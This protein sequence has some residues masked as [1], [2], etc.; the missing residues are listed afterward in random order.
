[1]LGNVKNCSRQLMDNAILLAFGIE[2]RQ[3]VE[4]NMLGF[5]PE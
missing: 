2:E 5:V 4:L 3:A 1:M